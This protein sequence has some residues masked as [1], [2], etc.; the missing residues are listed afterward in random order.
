VERRFVDPVFE[1]AEWD[2]IKRYQL[3]KLGELIDRTWRTN[4][5]YRELWTAR[6]ARC[7]PIDSFDKFH[8]EIPIGRKADLVADQAADPPMAKGLPR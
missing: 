1:R 6:G 8:A 5:F 4:A 7:A 2:E 3:G